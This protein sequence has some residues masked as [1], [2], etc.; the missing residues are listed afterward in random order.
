[1]LLCVIIVALAALSWSL[2]EDPIRRR[3]LLGALRRGREHR[4]WAGQQTRSANRGHGTPLLG[5][6]L[7]LVLV[8]TAGLTA[9]TVMGPSTSSSAAQTTAGGSA[10]GGAGYTPPDPTP[11]TPSGTATT[12]AAPAPAATTTAA[13]VDPASL[14]T[15]CTGVTH[16]GDST[17][18]GLMD[19]AALPNAADRIDAQYKLFGAKTVYTD[20]LGARS[21]V[22]RW[23]N[24][25]NAEDG[26]KTRQAAGFDGCWVLAMGLN[27]AANQ[28]VGGN[29]P[30]D[31]RID[32]LM[33][34]VGN[35]PVMWLTVKTLL[36][37]T[38]YAEN[39]M[40]KFNDAL[41]AACQRYPNMRVYDWAAEVQDN[42]FAKDKTHYTSTGWKE[43]GHRTAEAL[44]VAFPKDGQSPNTC[45][46]RNPS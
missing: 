12:S 46:I 15:S 13:P 38:A 24:Q 2:V 21:I 23:N 7:A 19:P 45:L 29:T 1:V 14:K 4:A 26:L 6:V 42:W 22:E 41:V 37:K 9:L 39:Q 20:I 36:T 35:E 33:Q 32:I 34:H 10:A 8:A 16:I 11:E 3:G 40:V 28:A 44:A 5:N 18:L 27:E 17:S 25:P 30:L 43:R 31:K